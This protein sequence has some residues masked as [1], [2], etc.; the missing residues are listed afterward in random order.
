MERAGLEGMGKSVNFAFQTERADEGGGGG[1]GV[2]RL[3][4]T[5]GKTPVLLPPSLSALYV[6]FVSE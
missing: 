6:L 2:L 5:E 4:S 1:G 3:Y